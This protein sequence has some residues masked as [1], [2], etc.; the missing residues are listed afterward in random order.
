MTRTQ[1]DVITG[2]GIALDEL[3]P[4]W[5]TLASSHGTGLA[6][7]P[8][9]GLSWFEVLGAGRLAV[10]AVRREGRLV[11]VAP[12]HRRTLL[13]QPVLRWL[14]HG[15][16][17]IGEVLATD[18][19]AATAL[20]DHL[21]DLGTP[22]QLSHVRL[23][24]PAVLALRR[25]SRWNV[26]LVVDE[27]IPILAL[28]QGTSASDLRGKRSLTRLERYRRALERERR[29]F[30]LEVVDD[31]SGLRRRWPDIVRVAEA[32]DAGRA[33]DNLCG[34]P[35]DRFTLRFLEQEA[36]VGRLLIVGGTVGDRWVAHEVGLR[37]GR[38]LQLWLSRFE[39]ELRTF[40]PGHL[41]FEQIVE[42]HEK[43]GVDEIDFGPGE[44]DY[45]L[46]WT[47]VGRDAAT[48]TATIGRRDFVVQRLSVARAAGDALRA[49]RR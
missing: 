44:N 31:L 43:L 35:Y 10:V 26:D 27:R 38:M 6:S 18:D 24:D 16:G 4:Q 34:P 32:A 2:P 22:L 33:R 3:V 40:S 23:D 5:E 21:F 28:P 46:A 30:A 1:V 25:H 39:P 42:R 11:A 13:G 49:V 45:K 29:P 8:S 12:L 47:T 41:L 37:C 20:W 36:A 48:L 9:Y 15:L 7:R 19:A 14:G 17:T